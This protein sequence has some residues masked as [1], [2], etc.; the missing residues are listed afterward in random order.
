MEFKKVTAVLCAALA[1]VCAVSCSGGE[2]ESSAKNAT[3]SG[4]VSSAV[5]SQE[6][7]AAATAAGESADDGSEVNSDD[8][9]TASAAETVQSET[10]SEDVSSESE[11]VSA[12]ES[13]ESETDSADES[14]TDTDSTDSAQSTESA[15]KASADKTSYESDNF[16]FEIDESLWMK[17]DVDTEGNI[18]A[19][20]TSSDAALVIYT[21]DE[22]KTGGLDLE[23]Y[24]E[25]MKNV[26]EENGASVDTYQK[27]IVDGRQ[28]YR[29]FTSMTYSESDEEVTKQDQYM[30]DSGDGTVTVISFTALNNAYRI[31]SVDFSAV[32]STLKIKA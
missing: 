24:A 6:E 32:L 14:D 26:Y 29:I 9:E 20:A 15:A 11:T 23:N 4:N 16:S 27:V 12:A 8:S 13:A 19:F 5:S 30:I 21:L 3:D 7:S 31:N 28:A 17:Y 1:A 18:F 2:S 10:D 22:E 25:T